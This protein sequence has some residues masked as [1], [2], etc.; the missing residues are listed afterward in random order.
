MGYTVWCSSHWTISYEN[1]HSLCPMELTGVCH[2]AEDKGDGYGWVRIAQDDF[3][4]ADEPLR[5]AFVALQDRF[6]EVTGGLSLLCVQY[7]DDMDATRG[8]DVEPYG[9]VVF[10][11]QGVVAMTPAG[12]ANEHLLR[13]SSWINAG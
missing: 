9:M 11:V 10:V 8:R 7:D 6:T 3:S 5:K 1:L 12:A 4:T 2:L 13:E